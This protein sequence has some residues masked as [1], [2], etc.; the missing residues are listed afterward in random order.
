MSQRKNSMMLLGALLTLA[1]LGFAQGQE[2]VKQQSR[3][4]FKQIIEI[5][6]TDSVGNVTTAAEALAK[7]LSDAGFPEQDVM[8][9][10]P[11]DRKKNLVVRL[12]GEIGRA[13]V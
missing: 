5:N 9:A 11:N 13:H 7:R 1:P 10:G 2:D 12:H 4:I 8:V 6:T 3:E